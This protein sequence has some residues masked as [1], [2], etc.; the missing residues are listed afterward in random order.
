VPTDGECPSCGVNETWGQV[1][2]GSYARK[3]GTERER[4]FNRKQTQK[5]ARG[6]RK[7]TLCQESETGDTPSSSMGSLS[8]A[9]PTK[10]SR[11]GKKNA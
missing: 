4:E 6:R 9:S 1:I 11:L 8:L 10:K 7:K 3:E 2:R 5:L